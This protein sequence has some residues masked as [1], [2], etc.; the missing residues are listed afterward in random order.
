MNALTELPS[1]KRGPRHY[2]LRQDVED[3]L[4]R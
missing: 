2:E 1:I 3:F 4:Y